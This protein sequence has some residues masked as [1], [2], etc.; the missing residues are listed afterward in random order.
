MFFSAP[1]GALAALQAL[2]SPQPTRLTVGPVKYRSDFVYA[3][4]RPLRDQDR[5][6]CGKSHL[7]IRC[8]TEDHRCSVG[9]RATVV[10]RPRARREPGERRRLAPIPTRPLGLGFGAYVRCLLWCGTGRV[11]VR[12]F[13]KENAPH[14]E[15]GRERRTVPRPA[16][17]A[18]ITYIA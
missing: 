13:R 4:G 17:M 14:G 15:N 11:A 16:G 18:Y 5:P 9:R 6:V 7:P 2:F 1:R 10:S 8:P 12:C 3:T